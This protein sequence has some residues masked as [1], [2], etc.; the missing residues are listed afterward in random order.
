MC[1]RADV[2][3]S[4]TLRVLM[5]RARGSGVDIRF[6]TEGSMLDC[7]GGRRGNKGARSKLKVSERRRKG[8]SKMGR[9]SKGQGERVSI[10]GRSKDVEQSGGGV[11]SVEGD[12]RAERAESTIPNVRM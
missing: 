2:A 11:D 1:K 6:G 7:V 9:V 8:M 4:E 5:N 3:R 10:G 12:E